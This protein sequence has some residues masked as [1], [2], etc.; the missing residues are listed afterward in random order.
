METVAVA[1]NNKFIMQ[2]IIQGYLKV[3]DSDL[4]I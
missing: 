4:L 2:F 3:I 1:V